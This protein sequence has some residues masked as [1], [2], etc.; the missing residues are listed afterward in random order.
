MCT[1]CDATA[2]FDPRRH[3]GGDGFDAAN[4]FEGSD[5]PDSFS[6]PYS[7]QV[8]GTF[9]GTLT[10]GL[11]STDWVAIT[12]TE[13]QGYQIRLSGLDGGGGSLSDP[14]LRVYD[15][16]DIDLTY[17]DD[18]GVGLDALISFL[19]PTTGT[20]YISAGS[21]ENASS[22]SYSLSVTSATPPPVGTLDELATFLTDG[23]W[24]SSG[25]SARQWDT[26]TSNQVTVDLSALTATGQQYAR[27]AFEVWEGVADLDF[28]EVTGGAQ[29]T[30][31]DNQTGAFATATVSGG[32]LQ[33]VNVNVHT[34]WLPSS[35]TPIDDYAFSTYIHEIGHAIGLGHQGAYNGAASFFGDATYLNDSWQHSVMSYFNQDEN[36]STRASYANILTAMMVD[37]IAAQNLYGAPGAA[38]ATAGNTT[39]GA[40]TNMGGFW[41]TMFSAVVDG[42]LTHY[43]GGPPTLTIYDRDGIDTVDL[44]PLTMGNRIDLRPTMFSDVGGLTQ[45]VGIARGTILENVTTG[46]G[47]DTVTGNWAGNLIIANDG[48]D[49][50]LGLGGWDTLRGGGGSDTAYGGDGNDVL[51]GDVG[52]DQMYGGNG[53]DTINGGIDNDT[54]GGGGGQDSVS[55]NGGNDEVWG[56]GGNDTLSGGDGDDLLGGGHGNDLARGN[57]GNDTVWGG[58]GNDTLFGGL[59]TD[60]LG[61]GG[62]RDQIW[63]G[64]GN[65]T[66]WGTWGDDTL[67][68]GDGNDLLGGGSQNDSL[69]GGSGNDTLLGSWGNDTLI[70]GWDNDS[71]SGGVGADIFVFGAGNGTDE[72]TDFS[73]AEGDRL[74]LDDALWTGTHGSLSA[75]QVISTFGSVVGGNVVLNFGAGEVITLTGVST[76]TGLDGALDIV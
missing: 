2:T 21:Y 34:S 12:L 62:G 72:I 38:S 10:A 22:G 64:S 28:V 14:F 29:I 60:E 36:T 58:D 19:A 9:L 25:R 55:G 51:D 41:A 50:L 39:W 35:G 59:D 5:A 65:D 1:L 18:S 7:M 17:N 24:A 13:G 54:V 26:S 6:T 43:D 48:D 74:E 45:N 46:V 27:W 53:N 11:D 15:S 57:T 44:S 23:Y 76:T 49:S 66:L 71:L 56:A 30:F 3:P 31:D 40:G 47:N 73:R 32:T 75:A 42:N 4:V 52:D 69:S 67:G 16:N 70:G 61:G 37:V 20:Y 63:G 68:G 8:G 33:S